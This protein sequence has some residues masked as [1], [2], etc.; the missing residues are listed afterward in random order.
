MPNWAYTNY[1]LEGDLKEVESLKSKLDEL[2]A[3]QEPLVPNG[4]G[5]LWLG[6][7]VTV[8]GG[9]WN[10]VYCRGSIYDYYIEDGA[11]RLN[12]ESAWNECTET[13]LLFQQRYP[14]LRIYYSTEEPG[15]EIY[16]TNDLDGKYFPDR[17]I[18]DTESDGPE[19]FTDLSDAAVYAQ[20]LTGLEVEASVESIRTAIDR[21][22]NDDPDLR[23][24]SFHSFDVV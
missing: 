3:M 16:Q 11:L 14:N 8:L 24:A 6:C 21:W 18:I 7:I 4:F 20:A 19:Y 15:M 5:N 2:K 12:V 13:R 9:D 23:W 10:K 22:I 17:Y 1:V